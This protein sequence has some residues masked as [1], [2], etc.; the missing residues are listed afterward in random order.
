VTFSLW[1]NISHISNVIDTTK[2]IVVEFV[3][4]V[5]NPSSSLKSDQHPAR[6]GGVKVDNSGPIQTMFQHVIQT[7]I[8]SEMNH[9]NYELVLNQ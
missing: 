3:V 4:K 7:Q 6:I 2:N 5:L 8:F 9:V 1:H